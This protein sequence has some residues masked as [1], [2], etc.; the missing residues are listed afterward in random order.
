MGADV[1]AAGDAD[2]PVLGQAEVE[3]VGLAHAVDALALEANRIGWAAHQAIGRRARWKAEGPQSRSGEAHADSG[4]TDQA[5]ATAVVGILIQVDTGIAAATAK[6][7]G[8]REA[9]VVVGWVLE[10]GH[11][12]IQ[13]NAHACK[14]EAEGADGANGFRPAGVAAVGEGAAPFRCQNRAGRTGSP[15]FELS[16]CA[17]G[18]TTDPVRTAVVAPR[19]KAIACPGEAGPT[20][21]ASTSRTR[22]FGAAS[23][24][25]AG[26]VEALGL[27]VQLPAAGLA[28]G[29]K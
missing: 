4:G 2:G 8:T 28:H 15:A 14:T 23:E 20:D 22:R 5:T 19:S 21:A 16:A 12:G 7:V 18:A 17:F 3:G 25:L 24:R 1:G 10:R 27:V 29:T 26:I 13:R 11:A 6:D 9:I